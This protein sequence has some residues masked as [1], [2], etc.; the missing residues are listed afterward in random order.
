MS[1]ELILYTLWMSECVDVASGSGDGQ[2]TRSD[3][4]THRVASSDADGGESCLQTAT[5]SWGFE[6][7]EALSQTSDGPACLFKLC[8]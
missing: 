2:S 8:L 1:A 6:I 4:K 3:A 7:E 5:W